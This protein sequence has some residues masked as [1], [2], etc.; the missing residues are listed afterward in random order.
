MPD[1]TKPQPATAFRLAERSNVEFGDNGETA[2]S[3]PINMIA[4]SP[5]PVDHF[6]WG[7]VYH[8]LEGVVLHKERIPVDYVHGEEVGYLNK[9]RVTA[10]GLEVSGALTPTR[11]PSD[12][13]LSLIDR[14]KAGV[15]YEASI[16]FAGTPTRIEEVSEGAQAEVNGQ[17]VDG[18]CLIFREWPLRGVAVCPYGADKMTKSE[19]DAEGTTV[20]V[21]AE[22]GAERE[23]SPFVDFAEFDAL[24]A[25]GE[26]SVDDDQPTDADPPEDPPADPPADEADTED[27]TDD[28]P[29]PTSSEGDDPVDEPTAT[30]TEPAGD[31]AAAALAATRAELSRWLDL[32]G[33]A[34]AKA[35]AA[36]ETIEQAAKA[37][38]D[39][40]AAENA[41]LRQ[42]LAATKFAGEDNPA[43]F[44]P[45]P[46]D[47]EE[48]R[49][50]FVRKRGAA[51]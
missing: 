32:F 5:G 41:D 11:S 21:I 35:F 36:G 34:G 42:R 2:K 1:L 15:P 43:P 7:R 26:A 31:P 19:F 45:P 25:A 50:T 46:A 10:R 47:P 3:V 39:E 24:A 27:E 17:T 20:E 23:R 28:Q 38:I 18:P 16:N 40:L 44:S 29:N 6:Y 48:P 12:P 51:A 22:P 4:R 8:D 37:R 13:L 33:E 9:F 49:K 14:G 30:D